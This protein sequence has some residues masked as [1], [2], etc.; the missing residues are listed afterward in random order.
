VGCES[1]D[2]SPGSFRIDQEVEILAPRETVWASLLDVDGWWCHRL[3]EKGSALALEPRV[4]GRFYER[5]G[6]D[7][8]ALWGVVTYLQ[9]PEVLRLAGPLGSN[10]A[11]QSV[12]EYRLESR[13]ART[14]LKLLH[15]CSGE[16]GPKTRASYDGGWKELW[17]H[18]GRL[19]QTGTRY[20]G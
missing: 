4:G 19:A 3:R 20:G 17:E 15:R 10:G 6:D 1:E 8:G 16:I 18:L 14:T 2:T 9:K 11:S 7:E 5:W 13:G 12:Y